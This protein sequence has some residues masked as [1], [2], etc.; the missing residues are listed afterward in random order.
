M[1]TSWAD[2][3]D[4]APSGPENYENNPSG[5]PVKPA[6]APPHPRNKA[7]ASQQ[8]VTP[9]V[10]NGSLPPMNDGIN[11]DAYENIPGNGKQ[12]WVENIY[13]S[14]TSASV[15]IVVGCGLR[16][17]SSNRFLGFF[18]FKSESRCFFTRESSGMDYRHLHHYLI[19][20]SCT[21]NNVY[22]SYGIYFTV[23]PT[24]QTDHTLGT[25]SY[26]CS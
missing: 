1:S 3:V 11:Y 18:Y 25:L 5:A 20:F 15:W 26:M 7:A 24:S 13:N 2:V 9:A 19:H 6:Y 17:L 22:S 14:L 16:L 10:S 12:V 4:N 23:V 21:I 8:A